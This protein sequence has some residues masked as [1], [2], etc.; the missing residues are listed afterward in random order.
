MYTLLRSITLCF[1]LITLSGYSEAFS[2]SV[3]TDNAVV[4][5]ISEQKTIQPGQIFWIGIHMEIR[6]N[7]YVYYRNP[8]DSGMPM[9][10]EWLHEEDF[11]IG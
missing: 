9:M 3:Q 6:D 5:L 1:L 2:Q 7:W 11:S 8:G 4:E 10:V